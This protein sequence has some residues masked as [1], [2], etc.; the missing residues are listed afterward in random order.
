MTIKIRPQLPRVMNK[1][2]NSASIA[3]K[4]LKIKKNPLL[5]VG[6][7]ILSGAGGS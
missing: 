2:L 7:F 3:I 5:G 4:I 1:G 6:L